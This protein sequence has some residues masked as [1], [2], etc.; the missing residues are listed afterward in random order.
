MNLE[1]A[2]GQKNLDGNTI[3]EELTNEAL[4]L[5]QMIP[6]EG[7]V[8]LTAQ[9]INMEVFLFKI[10]FRISENVLLRL[11]KEHEF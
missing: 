10:F 6:N 8:T 7:P 3:F 9:Q 11:P 1:K 2:Q 4:K 5:P